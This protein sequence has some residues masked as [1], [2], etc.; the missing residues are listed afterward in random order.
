[1]RRCWYPSSGGGDNS[2]YEAALQRHR[3]LVKKQE[4]QRL[5]REFNAQIDATGVQLAA[6]E[7]MLMP[8][9]NKPNLNYTDTP[10]FKE[11]WAAWSKSFEESLLWAAKRDKTTVAMVEQS[12][13]A[14]AGRPV[15][16]RVPRS[17]AA[18]AAAG[19][20]AQPSAVPAADPAKL[21]ARFNA[22]PETGGPSASGPGAGKNE[23][24][25]PGKEGN[26]AGGGPVG[27]SGTRNDGPSHSERLEKSK[28]S[29]EEYARKAKED[30][31]MQGLKARSDGLFDNRNPKITK[32]TSAL[33]ESI[34]CNTRPDEIKTPPAPLVAAPSSGSGIGPGTGSGVGSGTGSGTGSGSSSTGGTG[35]FY[36]N[37]GN[38]GA[39]VILPPPAPKPTAR[40]APTPPAPV[41]APGPALARLP[42]PQPPVAVPPPATM[43]AMTTPAPAS[44][45]I[46]N[47]EPKEK[48]ESPPVVRDLRKLEGSF[49]DQAAARR[50]G[51]ASGVMGGAGD[52]PGQAPRAGGPP[53]Q[54]G[55]AGVGLFDD[56][57]AGDA[58]APVPASD[59]LELARSVCP[60]GEMMESDGKLKE[61]VQ[62]YRDCVFPEGK[63]RKSLAEQEGLYLVIV[64][65]APKV[66]PALAPSKKAED[67]LK[68]L[69]RA[70][71][72]SEGRARAYVETFR[73]APWWA[74]AH[75]AAGR[76]FARLTED[77]KS[78]MHFKVFLN[79]AD[80]G[81]AR[82]DEVRA[83]LKVAKRS[84]EGL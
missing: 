40:P 10:E 54:A 14:L 27:A 62:S 7:N 84:G 76:T 32:C 65:L 36:G 56:I 48:Y 3:E 1:M 9:M 31:E 52:S 2:A 69:D 24:G 5:T 71:A 42:A 19:A 20:A 50:R 18:T 51:G 60:M 78:R 13:A 81:D 72:A 39:T 80:K 22:K 38:S 70:D 61:A 46:R 74:D 15:E 67:A 11:K 45:P 21:T 4:Q 6:L 29:P 44:A 23:S 26:A 16:K 75:Y 12:Q 41:P 8:F 83:K 58:G 34:D 68:E 59:A 25:P 30:A 33:G 37:Q 77:A 82:V 28:M 57:P 79:A 53:P 66:K 73:A 47:P 64:K 63:E 43:P 35:G 55:S 17:T 49:P